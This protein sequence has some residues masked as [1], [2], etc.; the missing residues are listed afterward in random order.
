PVLIVGSSM[1]GMTLSTLL[2]KHGV[3]G[4]ITVERHASTAIHPRA[5]LFMPRSM[6]IYRE[7]G[8]YEEMRAESAKYYDE[9]AGIVD[10]ESLAGKFIQSWM[11]N[12]NEGIEKLSPTGRLFL[13]QNMFEPILHHQAISD[14]A[15]LRFSTEMLSFSQD[16]SGV[17]A[18]VRNIDTGEKNL[19]RASYMVAC[20]GS[21]SHV[22]DQL[23]IEVKGYGLLSH[24]LTIYFR[25][26]VERFIRGK[27]NG[28]IYINNEKLRG[29]I[30]IDK[31]GKQGFLVVISAGPKGTEESR[32]PADD[33]TD[34]RA[35]ELLR[36][37]IGADV[38]FDIDL[39]HK[40]R[41]V[42]DCAERFSKGRVLLAGD[43]AHTVTP[44]GGFG[45][46]T[47]IQDAHNLAWKLA[48]VLRGEAG[49][50]LV[51]ETYND[52]RHPIGQKTVDQVFVRFIRRSAPELR[53][54]F[55]ASLEDELPDPYMELGYRY[56]SRALMTEELGDVTEDPA[57]SVAR[58]GSMARHVHVDADG[59]TNIPIADLLK[60]TFVLLTGPAA[61]EWEGAGQQLSKEKGLPYIKTYRV[62]SRE[63]EQRYNISSE[64]FVLVRPDAFVAWTVWAKPDTESPAIDTLRSVMRRILCL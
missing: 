2:A 14:G 44:H 42:C 60:G 47:G 26:D 54:Q 52:E 19:I 41:A 63:F 3:R 40:W 4:C 57:T 22:R 36:A 51:E 55:E 59:R 31:T 28:V 32:F 1:V 13:T 10:V 46:N 15:Q 48:A 50:A 12:I 9:K 49:R 38:P 45:G 43:A 58:P 16:D 20:D 23:C 11:N 6:E 18:L 37:A 7:L 29:F 33:I 35:A 25:A 21:R 56:H 30:R 24:A 5:A 34:E 64:G 17:T 27:Y 62:R 39:I 53:Q 8:L 61:G